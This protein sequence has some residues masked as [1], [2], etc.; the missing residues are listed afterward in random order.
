MSDMG[1][2][3]L[4]RTE[5]PPE[6]F[7]GKHVASVEFK[8]LVILRTNLLGK[9]VKSCTEIMNLT[10][11]QAYSGKNEMPFLSG[12]HRACVIEVEKIHEKGSRVGT[13][14]RRIALGNSPD[15]YP[16]M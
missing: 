13:L 6:P 4:T 14:S 2:T 9:P 5:R 3:K 15:R 1:V 16:P 10:F 8:A 11:K 12:I 7:P